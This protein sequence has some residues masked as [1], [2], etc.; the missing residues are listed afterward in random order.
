MSRPVPARVRS[1]LLA[2]TAVWTA[3][4]AACGDEEDDPCRLDEPCDVREDTCVD[5]LR[6]I[7]SCIRGAE[8]SPP[9][10]EYYTVDEYL[11]QL[12]EVVP[13]TA[14]EQ[15][16]QAQI[17]AAYQLLRFLPADWSPA[18]G[19]PQ[20][21]APYIYYDW[22]RQAIVA[23]VDGAA[24]GSE[25]VSLIYALI[26][27]DRD[28]EI[29]IDARLTEAGTFDRQRALVTLLSGEAT[30]FT[31][32]V[33]LHTSDY[34]GIAPDII[35]EPQLAFVRDRISDP[36]YTWGEAVASFQY[37]YGADHMRA[38]Y[39]EDGMAGLDRA[40]EEHAGSTAAILVGPGNKLDGALADVDVPLADPPPG[41]R[42]FV[43][44]SFGPVLYLIH[45]ARNG[46][47]LY[48][49]RYEQDL[50]RSW[51]GDRLIIAGS[52]DGAQVAVVW[53]IAGPDGSVAET[54]VLASD[55]ETQA[56]FSDIF[57]KDE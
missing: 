17:T 55:L 20:I 21:V 41:F 23:V 12:P 48:D 51:V 37:Y 36:T 56:A 45:L 15:R 27:A 1:A 4:A 47:A 57:K 24:P 39:I 14:D 31:D 33:K 30:F 38:L 46:V 25:V 28:A 34:A 2:C 10:I 53:Q 18:T 11:E 40:Y 22:A 19:D 52:D 26:L 44:N 42:Y 35:Y 7:V 32:L 49:A 54:L 3:L 43:Q 6:T 8:H 50:A 13:P 5:Q 29:S 16:Q 9:K